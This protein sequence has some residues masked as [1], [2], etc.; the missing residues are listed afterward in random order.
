VLLLIGDNYGDFDDAYRGS[1]AER[2][3]AFEA[4]RA[5][6][7]REWIMLAN[8]SYGSFDTAIYGHDFKKPVPE[9]RKASGTSSKAGQARSTGREQRAPR[10]PPDRPAGIGACSAAEAGRRSPAQAAD[11]VAI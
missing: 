1:E 11:C 6:F 5:H 9:Q 4:N 7:G 8:P 3:K 2:L 10:R